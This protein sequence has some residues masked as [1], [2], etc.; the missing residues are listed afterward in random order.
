M[1]LSRWWCFWMDDCNFYWSLGLLIKIP[2][3]TL[4]PH[5]SKECQRLIA[6]ASV[7]PSE[8]LKAFE[9]AQI[10][11]AIEERRLSLWIVTT[12]VIISKTTAPFSDQCFW[13]I[14]LVFI[15]HFWKRINMTKTKNSSSTAKVGGTR[16]PQSESHFKFGTRRRPMLKSC[17]KSWMWRC[18]WA[19]S[20][21][22]GIYCNCQWYCGPQRDVFFVFMIWNLGW[23]SN[24]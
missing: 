12:V 21:P 18:F 6:E 22:V 14:S 13:T 7:E 9:G 15:L 10:L 20:S 11:K 16:V 19:I 5:P 8:L 23:R 3:I 24:K 1:V 17:Q 2:F 4:V